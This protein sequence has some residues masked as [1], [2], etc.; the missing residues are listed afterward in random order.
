MKVFGIFHTLYYYEYNRYT[1]ASSFI[2]ISFDACVPYRFLRPLQYKF[3][4]KAQTHI[5]RTHI[6]T[7]NMNVDWC[8]YVSCLRRACTFLSG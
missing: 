7:L 2:Y 5:V 1:G 4:L 6:Y 3:E 8:L